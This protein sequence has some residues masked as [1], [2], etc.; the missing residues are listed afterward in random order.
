MEA[1]EVVEEVEVVPIFKDK[2]EKRWGNYGG[3]ETNRHEAFLPSAR[4]GTA[5]RADP[6][7]VTVSR[8]QTISGII[9]SN[10]QKIIARDLSARCLPS[11]LYL[12]LGLIQWKWRSEAT[13]MLSSSS[14]KH[15]QR[16]QLIQGQDSPSNL[17]SLFS[18]YFLTRRQPG[19]GVSG[20]TPLIWQ[21]FT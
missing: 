15:S 13:Q 9:A 8:C 21:T 17:S 2:K 16:W 3:K 4:S 19:A 12:H 6:P 7:P 14:T 20:T 11:F 18:R 10:W 5:A 1:L